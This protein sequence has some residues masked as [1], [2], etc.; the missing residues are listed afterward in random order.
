MIRWKKR[1]NKDLFPPVKLYC[2]APSCTEHETFP[3]GT[4]PKAISHWI[5]RHGWTVTYKGHGK[6]YH[7]CPICE[8]LTK[9]SP[10]DIE[11]LIA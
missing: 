5:S 2:D 4:E 10:R 8:R 3:Y 9:L 6:F 11:R 1:T 7:R